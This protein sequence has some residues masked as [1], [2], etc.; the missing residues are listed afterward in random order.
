MKKLF[1]KPVMTKE[2]LKKS[3]KS[4]TFRVGSY[5]AFIS[6]VALVLMVAVNLLIAEIP[7]KYV[8]TDLTDQDL[9]SISEQTESLVSGLSEDVTVYLMAQTGSEDSII[10]EMLGKYDDLSDHLKVV[11]KDPV[12]YPNFA[13]NY[14][15][16]TVYDNSLIVESGKR[17]K[18]IS[19]GEIYVTEYDYSDY[20]YTGQA[21]SSTTYNGEGVLTSAIDYVTSDNLPKVYTLT[22]HGEEELS[23][24]LQASVAKENIETE[25]LSLL[26]MDTVPSD[27]DCLIIVAPQ[28]DLSED[29]RDTILNYLK[30]GGKLVM[31]SDYADAG[32]KNFT[33]LGSEY[34]LEAVDGLVVE[35]DDNMHLRGYSYYLLPDLADDEITAPLISGGYYVLAPL[36]SGLKESEQ[37]RSSITVTPL[38][39]TSEKAYVKSNL[40]DGDVIDKAEG[41][42]EGM[43]IIGAK[44]VEVYNEVEST[45]V[46]YTSAGILNDSMDQYVSG[47]NT[48][49]F[50]NTIGSLCE[51][52]ESISIHAKSLDYTYLNVTSAQVSRISMI[53]V[54]LVPLTFIVIGICVFVK[55]K[56]R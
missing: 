7:S 38:L 4:R 44:A 35:G 13:Q 34:G 12:L 19:Y 53:L 42:P 1:K 26:S 14:T 46:W 5:S 11:Y 36:A 22:G 55:R 30:N 21:S 16:E 43:F 39:T 23:E 18:F 6:V 3:L 51:K 24:S 41:D 15:T 40:S 56:K 9:Y 52:T 20:Y 27:C 47:A 33:Y 54:G 28:T 29:E 17:S 2:S 45:L 48:D 32:L 49:L 31:F 25:S 8:K 37:H 10:A 50:I